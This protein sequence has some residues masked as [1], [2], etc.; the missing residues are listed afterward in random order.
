MEN[1]MLGS[2][3]FLILMKSVLYSTIQYVLASWS[4]ATTGDNYQN[5]NP[6]AGWTSIGKTEV[7][8]TF[9]ASITE[10]EGET[11]NYSHLIYCTYTPGIPSTESRY[12]TSIIPSPGKRVSVTKKMGNSRLF[13]KKVI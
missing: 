4:E 3:T 9:P 1:A 7:Y 5:Y 6:K 12:E 2:L 8:G 13:I 10:W 11:E